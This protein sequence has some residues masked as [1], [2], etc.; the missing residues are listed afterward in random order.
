MTDH[1]RAKVAHPT[2]TL[3]NNDSADTGAQIQLETWHA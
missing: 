1:L 3:M 2:K